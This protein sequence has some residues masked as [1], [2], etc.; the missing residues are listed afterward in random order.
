[1][2]TST[3]RPLILSG[4]D[5]GFF[6]SLW[7]FLLSAE[8][9]GASD[10]F[11]WRVSDL[12]MEPD[13][14][15]RLNRRFP[16]C[17]VVPFA[18]D[19][20]PPHVALSAKSYAWKPIILADALAATTSPVF[21]FDSA[22]LLHEALD[23]PLAILRTHGL[24]VLKSQSPLFRKCDPAVLDALH[25]P[26]EARHL[27][28][29]AAGAIGIDPQHPAAMELAQAWKRH[30]LEAAHIVPVNAA[31]FHKQDQ[32]LLNCLLLTAACKRE[33]TLTD[34]EIDISS[35]R[36]YRGLSTRNKV[37]ADAPA[38]LDPLLRL[39]QSMVKGAD[40]LYHRLRE[41]DDTTLDGLRRWYKEHFTVHVRN[42]ASGE[43]REIPGPRYGYYAD[44]FI[45]R[46]G[47]T[48]ALF[49]EE[50]QYARDNGR[51]V[52]MELSDAL[53][54]LSVKPVT[55]PPFQ[56]EITSH[57]S[58]PFVFE[59]D[60]VPHM[61]PETGER[62]SVDLF[63]CDRWPD[64]WVLRRRL[65]FGIDAVDSMVVQ[66]DGL[67]WLLTSVHDGQGNRHLEIH[68]TDDL[69]T[70]KFLPHPRNGAKPYTTARHGTGRNAGFLTAAEDGTLFRIMQHSTDH[71]GQGAC[72]MEITLL[73]RQAF[74]E[75]PVDC[76]PGL[77][78]SVTSLNTHHLSRCGD[79][80]AY[81]VRDRV[82]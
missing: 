7:Q 23:R 27:T 51:L 82:R 20:Y 45:W 58:Y 41:F 31:S 55:A 8:R 60:G 36:P 61:I 12:G 47:S 2:P 10:T 72:A 65:L 15:R 69:L 80:V 4:A 21:W 78:L 29:R 59:L 22:T 48:I 13:Q 54:P 38:W 30:A 76:I 1:M 5:A 68:F 57:A 39:R 14:L 52:V 63:I 19:S 9:T 34:D 75:V 37:A 44:P 49:M 11:R 24:W 3:P 74:Q 46:H 33:I 70:G 56:G 77:P 66:R 6:R 71:Y 32:S 25:V 40:R 43:A 28:E 42:L 73:D 67:W 50:F 18:F 26:L 53:E 81:D 62:R 17:E 16:W 64:R 35:F 79:L